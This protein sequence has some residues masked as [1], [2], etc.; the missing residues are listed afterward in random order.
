M[1]AVLVVVVATL[2]GGRP[3]DDA[4]DVGT[5]TTTRSRDT[6]PVSAVWNIP[7]AF[8]GSWRGA[9]E[10]GQR[11]FDLEVTIKPARIPRNWFSSRRPSALP[12]IGAKPSIA[13][14]P[15]TKPS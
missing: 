1:A 10:D 12:A 11:V 3:G 6:T 9:V 14:S 8:L 7:Q 4:T 2:V 13:S 15:L 5:T